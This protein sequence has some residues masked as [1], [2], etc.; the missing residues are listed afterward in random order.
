[1]LGF[2]LINIYALLLIISTTIIFF[3][4][5][6]LGQIE[7]ET[8]K[9]FLIVNLFMSISGILLGLVVNPEIV[10]PNRVIV[11][12]NKV[13]L[14]SLVL[15]IFI[16]TFYTMYISMKNKDKVGQC[17]KVI[18]ILATISVILAIVL[19]IEVTIEGT[20]VVAQGLSVMFT[21]TVFAIGFITQIICLI[22]NHKDYRNK[23]YIPLYVLI[24]L[25]SAVV[26]LMMINPTLN[27]IINPAFI[28]IAFVMYHTIENPDKKILNE[29]HNA[30]EIS[31]NA[32]EEK[33]MFLYN[34]TNEIRQV[35]K[36]ID[37]LVDNVLDTCNNK[38]VDISNVVDNA[39][40]I[41]NNI[42]KFNT[43]TNEILDISQVDI[44][45][46]KVYKDKYN[47]KIIIKELVQIYKNKSNNKGLE[48]RSSIASDIPEYLYGDSVS[49]KRALVTILDNA[50]KYTEYG[51]VEFN[52]DTILKNNVCRLVITVEDSGKGMMANEINQIFNSKE[53]EI[54]DKYNLNS[55]LYNTKKLITGMGGTIIANSVYSQGT[56]M[57]IVLDQQIAKEDSKLEKYE[58]ILDKKKVLLV[59]DSEA[60]GKIISKMLLDTNVD[61]EIIT[62]G[63][64]A[65]D[66]IRNKNRYDLILI[67]E[68]MQPLDGITVMKKL[69]EIR[70]FNT[71]VI[72]LTKNNN[73]EYNEDYLKYGFSNYL[74]KPIDKDSLFAII[75]KK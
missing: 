70:T 31:D 45:N 38:K 28:F 60:S 44:N 72:L 19:P 26:I 4:K 30:K 55:K 10:F 22:R 43:I 5:N 74:L 24:L 68:E 65:L 73:Y 39:K 51:Y 2:L 1:M 34:M 63:K 8:Y 41:K 15:W 27:Y 47:I 17:R 20:T 57:K 53:E 11:L 6:R 46:I 36:D 14:V 7:D 66:K 35:V 50:V 3:S 48:F 9:N 33:T 49:L 12:F 29:I 16:L 67:D 59:D 13:Y 21:Y 69:K 54:E 40:E 64:I 56:K 42:M 37:Y 58:Q 75:N 61:L 23:K 25:G 18:T 52:I 71:K 62:S 32:N